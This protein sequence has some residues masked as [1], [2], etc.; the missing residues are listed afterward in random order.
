MLQLHIIKHDHFLLYSD[1]F[2]PRW[3][4]SKI[5]ILNTLTVDWMSRNY[6][7]IISNYSVGDLSASIPSAMYVNRVREVSFRKKKLSVIEILQKS[8]L[9]RFVAT[10]K[11]QTVRKSFLW[12]YRD[13]FVT[14]SQ[15]FSERNENNSRYQQRTY[16]SKG[17]TFFSKSS[18]KSEAT[19]RACSLE[20]DNQRSNTKG[21]PSTPVVKSK[22][23]TPTRSRVLGWWVTAFLQS[24]IFGFERYSRFQFSASERSALHSVVGNDGYLSALDPLALCVQL[25]MLELN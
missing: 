13:E 2:A 15:D 3:E 8:I 17:S 12:N 7:N 5:K 11:N 10:S 21:K 22:T 20:Y 6:I 14:D 23:L 1:L 18:K 9:S 19:K 25:H 16:K 4:F 24:W